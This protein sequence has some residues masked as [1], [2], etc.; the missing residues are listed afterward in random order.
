MAICMKENATVRPRMKAWFLAAFLGLP[1]C[2]EASASTAALLPV[3]NFA[4]GE[5]LI[6]DLKSGSREE[7]CSPEKTLPELLRHIGAEADIYPSENYYYFSFY[8]AG[9]L[10]SGSLRLASDRRDKGIADYVCYE[11]Y[12]PWSS[13]SGAIRVQEHLGASD[14]LQLTKQSDR[15]YLISYGGHQTRFSLHE[16]DHQTPGSQLM[17]G[18]TRVGRLFDESGAAFELIFNSTLNH[19]YFLLDIPLSA[20]D[21]LTK[22]SAYTS[23]SR[24]TGFVYYYQLDVSRYVLVAV[25]RHENVTNTAFDGPG[26]QLPE[27]DYGSINFWDY[28]YRAY[29]DMEG[30]H[31]IGGTIKSPADARG[32]IFAIMPYRL[33]DYP[34]NL[35][36]IE[37]C[38]ESRAAET[39]RISCMIWGFGIRTD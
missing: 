18:E 14:G 7:A 6:E 30:R 23:I 5:T 36:F 8:R 19:F 29:P 17:P 25:N 3:R 28:V 24:R 37:N 11:A 4:L 33:Y 27:N 31:T 26:D 12:R 39:D 2:G 16:L 32:M 34:E 35:G 21:D 22:L 15:V 1:G 38:I 13:E 20:P 9:S 10:F